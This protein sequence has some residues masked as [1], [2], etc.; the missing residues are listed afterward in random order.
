[1]T[2][3]SRTVDALL[4]GQ[5]LP[6]AVQQH[7]AVCPACAALV[8]TDVGLTRA[9]AADDPALSPEP[10]PPAL[11]AAL[12]ADHAP[13]TPRVWWHALLAPTAA[14]GGFAALALWI[15]PRPDLTTQS[16]GRMALGV[17]LS[18]VGTLATLTAVSHG[19]ARGIGWTSRVRAALGITLALGAVAMVV[20]TTVV[21]EGSIVR[22]GL[23][24][25]GAR[26][27]CTL[28]GIVTAVPIAFL[29]VR[30]LR[31]TAPV[32][33]ELS[34]ALV[35]LGAG[36][37]GLLVQHLCCAVMTLDH[38]LVA[39]LLPLVAGAITGALSARRWAL[40]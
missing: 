10:L 31:G 6:A 8:E 11:R 22:G 28:E 13:R 34:G 37:G 18:V 32:Q 5:P 30:S 17:A 2:D 39:H 16:A 27:V 7:L 19:G 3:C 1:V 38:T 14:L 26:V 4:E 20:G 40:V 9:L 35:G 25:H 23:W 29:A 12:L 33:P 36:F 15:H 21:V 24:A